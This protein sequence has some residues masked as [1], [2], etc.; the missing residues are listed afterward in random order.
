MYQTRLDGQGRG[1]KTFSYF[2]KLPN[3]SQQFIC[4]SVNS[5]NDI[6]VVACPVFLK[7]DWNFGAYT[8]SGFWR[9]KNK[10]CKNCDHTK[11]STEV[12]LYG[13]SRKGLEEYIKE[14]EKVSNTMLLAWEITE[15]PLKFDKFY[16]NHINWCFFHDFNINIHSFTWRKIN[17]YKIRFY[18]SL[19]NSFIYF[20]NWKFVIF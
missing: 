12:W 8:K 5:Y 14:N 20:K 11:P 13:A 3:K 15:K 7:K 17:N 18:Y 1:I 16:G 10:P 19:G 2:S 4:Q 9:Q 6:C